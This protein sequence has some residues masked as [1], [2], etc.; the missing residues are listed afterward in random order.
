M[1]AGDTVTADD[2]VVRRVRFDDRADLDHYFRAD[3]ALPADLQLR[4]GVGAGELLP[5][6]AVG[7]AGDDGLLQLPVA[8]DAERV[9]PS[10]PPVRSS[11]STCARR[12]AAAA[13]PTVRARARR[14]SRSSTAPRSTRASARHGQ[15]QLVLG[16]AD[17]AAG[18]LLRGARR[19]RRPGRHRR[20]PGLRAD[21]GR[22]PDP[23]VGCGLGVRR[24]RPAR[25]ASPEWSCSSRC[26]DVDDLLAAAAAGQADVAV[27]RR[28]T[29]P[30]STPP[31]VDHLRAY[32]VR[33]V[34][35][36]PGGAAPDAPACAPPGSASA[37]LVAED[38]LETCRRRGH[39]R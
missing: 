15:R 2:L 35:V 14:A 36:V 34:A 33:P 16:V 39:G 13:R 7:P 25:S 21:R 38:E 17:E 4:R 11:T 5:A 37:R 3:A 28:S 8:V 1:G 12:A 32:A 31:A 19:R 24:P 10:V 20:P 6:H 27:R 29:P 22:R 18:A 26:V 9:P 30:A 23:R